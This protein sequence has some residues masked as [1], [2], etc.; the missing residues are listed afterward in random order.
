MLSLIKNS[1][2]IQNLIRKEAQREAN[3][4][5]DAKVK[6]DKE[7]RITS[8]TNIANMA[9][10]K[11]IIIVPDDDSSVSVGF[12][13]GFMQV[14]PEIPYVKDY[15]S[16]KEVVCFANYLPYNEQNLKAIMKLTADER[17][18]VFYRC[19]K[20]DEDGYKATKRGEK[21][22]SYEEIKAVIDSTDFTEKARE[23]WSK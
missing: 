23:Y 20:V 22:L 11:P 8:K 17:G 16:D 9:V 1:S 18:G 3:A 4:L 7:H 19:H 6:S 12:I 10:G 15:I 14:D 2:F 13:T 5:Y 21:S